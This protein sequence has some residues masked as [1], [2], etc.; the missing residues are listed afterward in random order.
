VPLLS[1]RRSAVFLFARHVLSLGDGSSLRTVMSGTARLGQ[2]VR[3]EAES[4]GSRCRSSDSTNRNWIQGRTRRLTRQWTR[5]PFVERLMGVDEAARQG[6]RLRPAC[7]IESSG[8]VRRRH[9]G[10]PQRRPTIEEWP[11]PRRWGR[12]RHPA[13]AETAPPQCGQTGLSRSNFLTG[14]SGQVL[15]PTAFALRATCLCGQKGMTQQYRKTFE[16]CHRFQG[17]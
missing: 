15:T 2:G 5:T 7:R 14:Y 17:V 16:F 12:R 8:S 4:E 1:G 13:T 9:S 10:R 3:R 6:D 11:L